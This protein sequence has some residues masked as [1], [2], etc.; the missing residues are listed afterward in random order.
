MGLGH[1]LPPLA[2][3][4]LVLVEE[5]VVIFALR[6]VLGGVALLGELVVD[7]SQLAAL[8]SG[9]DAVQADEEL[10]AVVG[11]GVLGVRVELSELVSGSV[12]GA[13]EPISSLQSVGLSLA[14]PGL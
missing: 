12:S 2:G 8:V 13:L 6:Y 10:G 14:V 4:F 7:Q 9:G 1:L 11:V 3:S 5:S